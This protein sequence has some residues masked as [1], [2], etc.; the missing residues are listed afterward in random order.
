MDNNEPV[1]RK[2]LLENEKLDLEIKRMQRPFYMQIGTWIGFLTA[3]AAIFG[4]II[5]YFLSTQKYELYEIKAEKAL[6]IEEKAKKEMDTL[7]T[8]LDSA[9]NELGQVE[10]T[11]EKLIK[12]II[13]ARRDKEKLY[14]LI[15]NLKPQVEPVTSTKNVSIIRGLI[16]DSKGIPINNTIVSAY[17]GDKLIESTTSAEGTFAFKANA[18]KKIRLVFHRPGFV[19]HLREFYILPDETE[20][21][22]R[23]RMTRIKEITID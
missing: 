8:K 14:Q 20:F 17:Q 1:K 23:I 22:V 11:K 10:K 7:T 4:L 18:G 12:E 2:I 21:P 16:T 13:E 3:M 15:N 6:L 5:Q 19:S 9:R